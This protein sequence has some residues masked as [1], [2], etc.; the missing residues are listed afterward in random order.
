MDT[1]EDIESPSDGECDLF[2]SRSR[3]GLPVLPFP[4]DHALTVLCAPLPALLLREE[5]G[6]EGEG[7]TGLLFPAAV[8]EEGRAR[9][10]LPTAGV[11]AGGGDFARSEAAG[12]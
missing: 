1:A 6:E 11:S 7:E 12:R 5:E 10:R 3:R 4:G 9:R 2:P 8:E